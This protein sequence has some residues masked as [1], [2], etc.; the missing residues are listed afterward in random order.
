MSPRFFQQRLRCGQAIVAS[1]LLVW[2]AF[3]SAN[4][5]VYPMTTHI[6]PE[7]EGIG[8]IELHS[9]SDQVQYVK[10]RVAEIVAPA[11]RDEREN[12]LSADDALVVSPQRL[13]L[14]P[15]STRTVRLIAPV[16]PQ[17]EKAYRVYFE[18]VDAPSDSTLEEANTADVSTKL[19]VNLVWGALVRVLPDNGRIAARL[20]DDGKRMQNTGT[21]RIGA[22]KIGR[23]PTVDSERNCRWVDVNRSV[24]PT[25]GIEMPDIQGAGHLVLRY[26]TS[27]DETPKLLALQP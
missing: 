23:C 6:G 14:A 3:A 13:V 27:Q 4:V 15:A 12:T 18:P 9:K 16:A 11:T 7:H 20:V 1:T 19:G 21:L 17:E 8:Q 2:S 10:V 24:Y 25:H 5:I 26:Q 22:L